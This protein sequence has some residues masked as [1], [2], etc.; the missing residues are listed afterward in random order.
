LPVEFLREI[1]QEARRLGVSISQAIMNRLFSNKKGKGKCA[2]LIK[3]AG[4][5]DK[6]QADQ[7]DKSLA[8]V[9]KVD[10]KDWV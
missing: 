8:E 6:K 4:T 5:W 3:F 1:K 7:F 2:D 10:K 9:R